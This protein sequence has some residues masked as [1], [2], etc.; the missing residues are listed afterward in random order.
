MLIDEQICSGCET[1][2]PYCPVG[3]IIA[4]DDGTVVVNLDE[5]VECGVCYTLN[6]CP[7]GAISKGQLSWLRTIRSE[8]SNAKMSHK[9]TGRHGR[10]TEEMKTND[11]TGRYKRGELGLA[12]EMGRPSTGSRLKEIEKLTVALAQLGIK[13]EENNP[14][15]D[16]IADKE[17]GLFNP[18]VIN[19][20][21]LSAIIE[22]KTTKEQLPTI[23]KTVT[24]I[25]KNIDTVFSMSLISRVEPNGTIPILED[26]Y[27]LGHKP[28]LQC[29]INCGLGRPLAKEEN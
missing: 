3:S 27:K 24:E 29:K 21:V 28:A 13:M 8:F 19:E 1:C 2:I 23:L 11:V 4:N 6:I 20:K 15:Y 26:L 16:L 10:G 22:V 18:E 25:A 5:C 17:K 14:L 9:K 7:T 12:I